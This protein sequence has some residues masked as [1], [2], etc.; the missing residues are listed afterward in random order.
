MSNLSS[1]QIKNIMLDAGVIYL[2][3]TTAS[4]PLMLAPTKGA[5]SFVVE[6][7]IKEIEFNGMRG[8]TKGMR[9]VIRQDASLTVRVMDMSLENIKMALAGAKT[10]VVS[11]KITEITNGDG[12]IADAE[13]IGDVTFVG[14]DMEGKSKVISL[15]NVLGD[16]NLSIEATDKE[17]GVVEIVFS[18]HFDA[19]DDTKLLYKITELPAP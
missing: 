14:V 18:A 4:T 10:T 6:N 19:T 9:R 3:Y 2:D 1:E 11:S 13:Y 12:S 7:E 8:K 16:N 15:F 5:N 17:E